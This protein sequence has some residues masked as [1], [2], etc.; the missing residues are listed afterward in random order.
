M[1]KLWM[2]LNWLTMV[3]RVVT[4]PTQLQIRAKLLQ[5]HLPWGVGPT[6]LQAKCNMSILQP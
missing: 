1:L 3:V 6:P 4:V 2:V 5:V